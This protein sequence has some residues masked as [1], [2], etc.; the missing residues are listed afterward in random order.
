MPE[1]LELPGGELSLRDAAAREIDYRIM[2]WGEMGSTLEGWEAFERGAFEG[3]DPAAVVL[4]LDHTDPAVGRG[5]RLEEREDAAYMTFRV[6][7]TARGDELLALVGDGVYRGASV[8]FEPLPGGTRQARHSDG[9]RINHRT[10]VGLRE[11]GATWRPTFASAQLM[12]VRSDMEPLAEIQPQAAPPPVANEGALEVLATRLDQLEERAR[13]NGMAAPPLAA[14]VAAELEVRMGDWAALAIR[15]MAGDQV[16][17]LE[18]RAL[19]EIITG[20]NMGVVPDAYRAELLGPITRSRP[21]LESTTAI[22]APAAGTRI[23]V[24]RIV[25]RPTVGV[26]AAEKDELTSTNTA[27]DTVDFG[28]VTVGGAGN[29]SLQLL[30]RSSP[31]FLGLY[32]SLL[33]EAYANRTDELALVDLINAGMTDGGALDPGAPTFGEAWS[34]SVTAT[35][36]TPN[37]MFMS[38]AAYAAF[39]DEKEPAG[40][41]GQPLYPSLAFIGGIQD[42]SGSG[43][44]PMRLNPVIVPA[45]DRL[46]AAPPAPLLAADIPAVI[47][48]P[49]S[50]FAWAEDG[51]YTL[52]AD[53]PGQAGR[54]VALVG[55]LWFAALY[56]GAFTSYDLVP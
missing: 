38:G 20:T 50:G 17:P 4:R 54:D 53:N 7:A 35:N 45:L 12:E 23:V 39:V 33:G 6:S 37:R 31:E 11:V 41:G 25:T 15:Q 52:Q 10:K 55:M 44:S 36:T 40:G 30:R 1:L 3:T 27:I 32:V 29:L 47:I 9:R 49:A 51:T 46:K 28:M 43:P 19:A 2:R 34:N 26:Q 5:I 42:T 22:T 16:S 18:I 14:A 48:G 21:F 24:P 8:G 13:Q 56:P